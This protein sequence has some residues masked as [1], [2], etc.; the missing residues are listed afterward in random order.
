MRKHVHFA[1]RACATDADATCHDSEL[2][3]ISLDKTFE[4][5]EALNASIVRVI[6]EAASAWG[7]QCLRYEIRDISPPRSITAAMELQAEAERR[8]RAN[9]LDSEGERQA[10]I[11]R[12][13]GM[14]QKVRCWRSP[15]AVRVRLTLHAR[16]RRADHS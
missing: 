5:R 10:A 1:A 7:L 16:T 15:H 3:K 8:K 13:E 14:K 12:A 6:N 4:E 9:V 11:N 2:G